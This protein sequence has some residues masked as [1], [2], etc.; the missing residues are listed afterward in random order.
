[1]SPQHPVLAIGIIGYIGITSKQHV[2]YTRGVISFDLA[3]CKCDVEKTKKEPQSHDRVKLL[4]ILW[5]WRNLGDTQ[6]GFTTRAETL[7]CF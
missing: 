2:V 5:E 4:S 6:A 1:M 7:F 3:I